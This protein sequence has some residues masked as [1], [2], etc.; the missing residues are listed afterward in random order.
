MTAMTYE[1]A[2]ERIK[3][4]CSRQ[5]KSE[6]DVRRKMDSWGLEEDTISLIMKY[7]TEK[8]FVNDK[9]FASAF[10]YNQHHFRKWGKIK[11]RMALKQK[12]IQDTLI[13]QALEQL[14]EKEYET[15]LKNELEKKRK[16]LK[17]KNRYELMARLLSFAYSRGYEPELVHLLLEDVV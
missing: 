7:L 16:S 13:E 17:G 8:N 5:E 1:Q 10:C 3:R 15:T 4:I 14:D 9:R 2:L 11:I 6:Y 12:R